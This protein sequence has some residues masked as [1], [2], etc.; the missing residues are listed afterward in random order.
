MVYDYTR[1]CL[2]RPQQSEQFSVD[3]SITHNHH[4]ALTGKERSNNCIA[5]AHYAVFTK[6]FTNGHNSIV[7]CCSLCLAYWL[8][9]REISRYLIPSSPVNQTAY[10]INLILMFFVCRL[11]FCYSGFSVAC[12]LTSMDWSTV[13]T[14]FYQSS[15]WRLLRASED[16]LKTCSRINQE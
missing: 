6:S 11:Y 7:T 13:D 4:S 16:C 3:S 8:F 1:Q 10:I 2:C 9:V 12:D 14:G 15:C 5:T